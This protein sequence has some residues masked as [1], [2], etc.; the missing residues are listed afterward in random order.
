MDVSIPWQ[1]QTLW[2]ATHYFPFAAACYGY[3]LYLYQ[4]TCLTGVLPLAC[5]ASGC[6]NAPVHPDRAGDAPGPGGIALPPEERDGCCMCSF[7]AARLITRAPT[8]A[9]LRVR[10]QNSLAERPFL[11]AR[12]S[13][14]RNLV[15]AVRGTLSL[16]DAVVD[17]DAAPMDV[18][19]HP[20]VQA[21][22]ERAGCLGVEQSSRLSVHR[23]MWRAAEHLYR[24]LESNRLLQDAENDAWGIVVLGHSLGAG[25]ATLLTIHLQVR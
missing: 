8:D 17:V 21:L 20:S 5:T 19:D 6:V 7:A 16:S 15:L 10:F 25:V 18:S 13:Q 3:R 4:S 12:D 9:F 22:L 23:G 11:L 24:Y 2:E 1:S 14:R